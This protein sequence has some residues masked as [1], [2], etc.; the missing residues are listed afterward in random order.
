MVYQNYSISKIHFQNRPL[1]V[2]ES[3]VFFIVLEE[4]SIV[5]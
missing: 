3:K 5:K 1:R 4:Y 2:F